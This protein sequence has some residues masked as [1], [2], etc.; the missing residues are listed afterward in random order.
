M[1]FFSI[2]LSAMFLSE[3]HWASGPSHRRKVAPATSQ[4]WRRR[5]HTGNTE[6]VTSRAAAPAGAARPR[7]RQ[8]R[9]ER[10]VFMLHPEKGQG[11]CGE[12]AAAPSAARPDR[13]ESF[14][15]RIC[16]VFAVE[17]EMGSS[18]HRRKARE[19][20]GEGEPPLLRRA[21]FSRRTAEGGL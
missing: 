7:A 2:L 14:N 8:R 13:Q 3:P 12:R 15:R 9:R 16:Q 20:G 4:P 17:Y 19:A 10:S 18:A 5:S 21:V 11:F 6:A 1:K